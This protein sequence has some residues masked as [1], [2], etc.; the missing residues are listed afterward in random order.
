MAVVSDIVD[1][2]TIEF[3]SGEF[4]GALGDLITVLPIVVALG[5]L[6][7]LPLAQTLV[8]FGVFQ[9]VWGLYYGLP[10]S[11]EPMKAL[12]GLAIAGAISYG[13]LLAA[14]LLAGTVL[15]LAGRTGTLSR[16]Q[17]VVGEPVVRGIQLGVGLV[18]AVSGVELAVGDPVLAVAA[19]AITL[20]VIALGY[21]R[22]SALVVLGFGGLLAVR[23]VGVPAPTVPTLSAF[24]VGSPRL[25]P[26]AVEGVAAQ[27]AMT[28]G[29]A[30]VAT[31]L[32]C[33]DLFDRDV[34]ADDLA[35]SMGTMCLAAVPAGALPMCHGSGGLAGKHAFGA[36]TGGANLILGT[37]YLGGALIVGIVAAF[38]M[39]VLG[40]L[41]VIVA[42]ELARSAV[43]TDELA[44]TVGIGI[45]ALA[46]NIGVAFVVG[47]GVSLLRRRV[48]W[49]SLRG[50]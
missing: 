50:V 43:A 41:L 46:V 42:A 11:V 4:T 13:E 49:Q 29:N 45:L 25:T 5:A 44:L 36:R 18:L 35:Q 39:A 2:R 12:A 28:I 24:P 47:I 20:G 33:S 7:P 48:D 9:I 1:R 10:M 21:R 23:T 37:V 34:S 15:V 16:L 22:A 8:F 30:A 40:V 27:L 32:L 14:G 3:G 17:R 6:T 26:G 38:P 19:V 31:S